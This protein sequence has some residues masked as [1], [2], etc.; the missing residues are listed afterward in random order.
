MGVK[1]TVLAIVKGQPTANVM[2][3]LEHVLLVAGDV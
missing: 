2:G 1:G 3:V